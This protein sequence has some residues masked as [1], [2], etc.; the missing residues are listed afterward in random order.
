MDPAALSQL[1]GP[2]QQAGHVGLVQQVPRVILL[3]VPFIQTAHNEPVLIDHVSEVIALVV[4]LRVV[5]T[6]FQSTSWWWRQSAW[7]KLVTK[8]LGASHKWTE[9]NSSWSL[10][11]PPSSNTWKHSWNFCQAWVSNS[12][13]TDFLR[14]EIT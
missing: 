13:L 12:V 5:A 4:G 2:L 11:G 1:A 6:Q 10:P 7:F 8:A 14:T 3:K 9:L